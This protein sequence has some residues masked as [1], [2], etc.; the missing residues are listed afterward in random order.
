MSTFNVELRQNT[1]S[2]YADIIYL[3]TIPEM[4]DG[5]LTDGKITDSLLPN[6]VFGG[7]RFT[8]V[9]SGFLMPPSYTYTADIK[10][11]VDDYVTANGGSTRG[12]YIIA[13][14]ANNYPIKCSVGHVLYDEEGNSIVAEDGSTILETGDWLICINDTGTAWSVINNSY[15]IASTVVNGLMSS[16]DKVKL[17]GIATGA[18]NYAHPTQTAIS[19]DTADTEVIDTLTVNT[20]GHV[21]AATK[22]TL[23]AATTSAPGTMSAAD[24]VK[25][26]GIATGANNYTHPAYS[27]VAYTLTSVETMATFSTDATGH[28]T[29]ATKQ[30]IR[31][32]S[33]TAT[34]IIELATTTE[35]KTGTDADRAMSPATTKAAIE[36]FS[37]LP[38]YASLA[39]ANAD[40]ANYPT[41]KL[42]LIIV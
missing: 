10:T 31:S 12:C 36:Y 39:V 16:E 23:P 29:G 14:N 18:N 38:V 34:G 26:D 30:S 27:A 24:K 7:M 5:L 15:R 28:V 37:G 4:V 19:V 1:G 40:A 33:T 6:Y 32:A 8:Q 13:S 35:G 25:L 42:A 21:T 9:F 22:R 11:I 17:D 3:K 2:A 41:G 20:L